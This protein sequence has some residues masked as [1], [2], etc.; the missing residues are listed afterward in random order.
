M[1]RHFSLRADSL[2]Q[3][4]DQHHHKFRAYEIKGVEDLK[5]LVSMSELICPECRNPVQFKFSSCLPS[6]H[7]SF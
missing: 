5:A 3:V 7:I 4:I 1:K 6:I 2:F